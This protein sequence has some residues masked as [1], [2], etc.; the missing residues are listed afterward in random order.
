MSFTSKE[1]IRF[2]LAM[3]WFEVSQE[4]SHKHF[5]HFIHKGKVT[6][7]HPKREIAPKTLSSILKQLNS[8]KEEFLSWLN[9]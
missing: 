3:G 2:A 4:G 5:K 6:I 7:P 8:S 9:G 1:L